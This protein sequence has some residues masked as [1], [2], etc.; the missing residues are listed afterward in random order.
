MPF[1]VLTELSSRFLSVWVSLAPFLFLGALLAG[2][3]H[4]I[5]PSQFIREALSGHRGVW[6]AVLIGVPLPLCSCGVIPAGLGLRKDGASEGATVG[7]LISTPQTGVDSVLVSASLLGLPFA[8]YKVI[9]AA[10]TGVIGGVVTD[11]L[12]RETDLPA[13]EESIGSLTASSVQRSPVSRSWIREA[14]EHS[15]SVLSSIWGW[16][17][18]GVIASAVIDYAIP[19]TLF[20]GSDATGSLSLASLIWTYALT[21]GLSLPLYVCATASVPIAA[22]LVAKGFPIGA[23]LVFLMA[24]PATNLATLGA[25]YR[26]LGKRPLLVYLGTITLGS[27]AFALSLDLL[28]GWHVPAE[29]ELMLHEHHG[30]WW[31]ITTSVILGLWMLNKMRAW[32][33]ERGAWLRR[34]M[35]VGE[36]A[37]HTQDAPQEIKIPISGLTCQGCV[38]RLKSA[39]LSRGDINEC[40]VSDELDV[41]W[42]RGRLSVEE[43]NLAVT[44]AGFSTQS[45]DVAQT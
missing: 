16:I 42:V 23:A 21:L 24:G 15:E 22:T 26:S 27:L 11:R 17:L 31:E 10:L 35:G 2:I 45:Q 29:L 3:I 14:L 5:L 34:L 30:A 44:S 32:I 41:L 9:A 38:R 40:Q 36:R 43:L 12:S 13:Q 1:S 18:I 4:V 19:D 7:F 28:L 8:I 33:Q 6:R 20:K 39:L 37:H 25:V